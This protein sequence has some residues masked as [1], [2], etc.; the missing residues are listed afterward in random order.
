[1]IAESETFIPDNSIIKVFLDEQKASGKTIVETIEL[2]EKQYKI[3][4]LP[5]SFFFDP[6]DHIHVEGEWDNVAKF[7]K[8]LFTIIKEK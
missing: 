4:V 7:E 2:L 3:K 5:T 1:M 8:D 6:S